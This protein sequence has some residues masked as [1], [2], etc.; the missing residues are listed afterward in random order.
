MFDASALFPFIGGQCSYFMVTQ[1]DQLLNH[2]IITTSAG[3]EKGQPE[4]LVHLII[5]SFAV[6]DF[7][8]LNAVEKVYYMFFPV[9]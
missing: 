6:G 4:K 8:I 3:T 2:G 1:P 9:I 5:S 7:P